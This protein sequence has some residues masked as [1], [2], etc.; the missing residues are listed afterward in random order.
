MRKQTI[1]KIRGYMYN[2]AQTIENEKIEVV[3]ATYISAPLQDRIDEK[4]Y[5]KKETQD[6]R[7]NIN[8]FL[9]EMAEADK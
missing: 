3:E 5:I 7:S 1:E 2:L 9:N 4:N 8:Q 6:L